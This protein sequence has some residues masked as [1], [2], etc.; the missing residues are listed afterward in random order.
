MS[1]RKL[2][3]M[4]RQAYWSCECCRR[5]ESDGLN[6]MSMDLE[7]SD[8]SQ[9]IRSGYPDLRQLSVLLSWYNKRDLIYPGDA[10]IAISGLLAVLS[11]GFEDGFLYGLPEGFF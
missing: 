6:A 8:L 3:F 7:Y 2:V 11:R 9:F 5:R 1:P 4:N 10:L